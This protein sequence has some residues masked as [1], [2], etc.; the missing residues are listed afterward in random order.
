M[1]HA[2]LVVMAAGMGSRYGGNKQVDGVGPHGE[3]L[4][5]YGI[6]DAARAGFDKVVFVIKPEIRDLIHRLAGDALET[7]RTPDGRKVEF[8]YAEQTFDSVPDFYHIPEER[9][10][11]FGT[12]HAVICAAD[13][14]KTPFAVMNAD[15]YYG[16][17]AF[18]LMYEA[19]EKLPET[20]RG[21]MVAYKLR[22]T[23]SDFGTV[24]RGVC[25]ID[26]GE[27]TAVK[28]TFKIG[29]APDGSIR[30]FADSEE[31][32]ALDG[33]SPVSM[34]FWG[35]TPWIFTKLEEYFNAFLHALPAGELKKECLLPSM[36]GELIEKGQLRVS[37]LHSD[38]KW[39][40]MTYHEDKDA[41]AAALKALHDAG[42]Y[43]PTLHG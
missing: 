37:V 3:I 8:C 40:G 11:P 29:K 21:C 7:L 43:P 13:C 39:F 2:T 36:V 34:N 16:P 38:A 33:E 1:Q 32:V 26:G 12:V 6:Y 23:V 20:G 10:K 18:T 5:N 27:M 30:S 17:G 19:L 4:M 31:G 14:I 42:V 9:T 35:F 24:T 28:E 41:V 15:D 22:N 25:H